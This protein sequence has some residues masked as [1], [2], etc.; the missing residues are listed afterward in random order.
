MKKIVLTTI[1]YI[2]F[3]G[4]GIFLLWWTTKDLSPSEV[5]QLKNSLREANYV[6]ILPA[7]VFLLL[8]HYSRSLRWKIL[9]EPLNFK[10]SNAN[11]FFAVMLGYFFNL[12]VPRLGEVMK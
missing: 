11:T 8:S 9:M 3:L 10:P 6:L 4:L 7:M 1:Q 2:F 5:S 12:L